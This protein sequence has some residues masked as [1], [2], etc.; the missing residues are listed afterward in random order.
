[1]KLANCHAWQRH[2][3]SNNYIVH[4]N[5]VTEEAQ[6]TKHADDYCYVKMK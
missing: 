6:M 2:T 3:K 1:M 4:V 5:G